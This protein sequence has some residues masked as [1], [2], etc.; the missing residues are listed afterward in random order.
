M[1][2]KILYSALA[3]GSVTFI[4]ITAS[5]VLNG[6]RGVNILSRDE[7]I[8]IGREA[9]AEIEKEYEVSTNPAD[10][11]LVETIGQKLVAANGLND[12]PYTFKVLE[13]RE[14]NAISLPGGPV[15]VFR[16]LI[17]LTEGNNDELAAVIAHEIGHI[18]RRHIAQMYSRGVLADLLISLGTEG[19][20]RTGAQLAAVLAQLQYS[21]DDEY[22]SDRYSIRFTYKAGYDPN[23][24]IRFF[25]K[26]KRLEKQGKGDIIENN[27]RTH[28]LTE[29]RIK[30]AKEE[31][32]K[33][34]PQLTLEAE[35]EYL[36]S[37]AKGNNS[38]R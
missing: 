11:K 19:T 36:Q 12:F 15:Y 38:E 33:L 3:L 31:I 18:H 35:Q 22:E 32:A 2:R 4:G 9:S 23:G 30:R 20:V 34:V 8:R 26:M 14:I 7:E 27:L 16:G 24:I 29:N 6:C 13:I 37:V 1:K 21:R 28:P 17:D 5:C 10:I 25:E